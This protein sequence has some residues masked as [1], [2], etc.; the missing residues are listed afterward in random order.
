MKLEEVI[1]SRVAAAREQRGLSQAELGKRLG[2]WL[3][4]PWARQAVW[5]AE[6]GKR[7]FTAAELVAFAHVLDVPVEHLLTPP[8][9][10]RE[11]EMPSTEKLP[12]SVLAEA[13][14]PSQPAR[15]VFRDMQEALADLVDNLSAATDRA[16]T[17]GIQVDQAMSL[18]RKENKK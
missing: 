1:G 9:E 4:K 7:A 12:R 3:E 15:E 6:Q 8:V 17:L 18:S 2:D 13:T 16:A 14:L 11:V 10:V 5:S